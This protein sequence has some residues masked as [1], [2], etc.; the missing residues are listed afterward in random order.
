MATD[1]EFPIKGAAG[2]TGRRTL[3]GYSYPANGN[4]HNPT[5]RYRWLLLNA[6]RTVDSFATRGELVAAAL[7]PELDYSA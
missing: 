6:G 7:D 5:P 2:L 4:A 3:A 1:R